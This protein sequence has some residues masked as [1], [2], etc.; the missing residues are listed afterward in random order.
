[1]RCPG[2]LR[3]RIFGREKQKTPPDVQ[4]ETRPFSHLSASAS[5]WIPSAPPISVMHLSISSPDLLL[6]FPSLLSSLALVH[7][8]IPVDFV[9]PAADIHLSIPL[10]QSLPLLHQLP[11][12][13]RPGWPSH[14]SPHLLHP[15]TVMSAP[16]APHAS[17]PPTSRQ[18]AS[19]SRLQKGSSLHLL[20][21]LLLLRN[22]EPYP[23]P[24]PLAVP[25]IN[26]P[27]RSSPTPAPWTPP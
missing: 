8:H 1:M 12:N 9:L 23:P 16:S 26:P 24:P 21:R 4:T 15:T 17:R 27:T 13:T 14:A 3:Y 2:R 22:L 5:R 20:L 10:V 11:C 7:F 6:L 19:R 18:S 25:P